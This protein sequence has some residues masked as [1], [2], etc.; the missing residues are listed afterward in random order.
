[1]DVLFEVLGF[2][3]KALV[4]FLTV[5]ACAFVVAALASSRRGRDGSRGR[6][7]VRHLNEELEAKVDALRAALMPPKE[8]KA[9]FKAKARELKK[10]QSRDNK[11]FVLDFKG[12]LMATQADNLRD[13]LSAVLRIARPQDEVVLRLESA[14]GAV[15]GYGF[16]AAQLARVTRA[17][18]PLTVCVDRVAASGGYMMAC[19][20]DKVVASPFALVGSIGV[21]AP[22]PNVHRLLDRIGVEYEN[23]TAGR[24][25][26]PVSPFTAPDPEGRKKFQEEIEEVHEHFKDFV[27]THRPS[28]DVEAIATG[29]SWQAIRARE[30][31]LVDEL[32][33]SDDYLIAK[34][35]AAELYEVSYERSKNV[36]ERLTSA[37]SAFVGDVLD[38]VAATRRRAPI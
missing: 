27:R 11:V 14:G 35:E 29:E 24:Y 19:V 5:A 10:A 12:D 34:L 38:R 26:R 31:G 8:V 2:A 37:V 33:T 23:A 4:V 1:M 36:R 15:H 32:M 20:A 9:Y 13:E 3:G 28:L 16:A 6:L 17:E 7:T 18:V 30:L 21:A 22:L 25:K